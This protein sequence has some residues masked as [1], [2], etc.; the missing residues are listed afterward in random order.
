[1]RG[2]LGFQVGARWDHSVEDPWG[3]DPRRDIGFDPLL[4]LGERAPP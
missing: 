4:Q 3:H 2:Y 1:M